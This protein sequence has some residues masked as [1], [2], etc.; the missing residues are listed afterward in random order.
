MARNLMAMM[1]WCCASCPAYYPPLEPRR[2]PRTDARHSAPAPPA[3]ACNAAGRPSGGSLLYPQWS[4]VGV[5][6]G[7]GGGRQARVSGRRGA[8]EVGGRGVGLGSKVIYQ[9]GRTE[10]RKGGK[11]Q[12]DMD[13]LCGT[14]GP[15][16]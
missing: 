10:D 4:R 6:E 15:P 9:L 1:A 12:V 8:E 7:G 3:P 16:A 11:G 13:G 14:G 5:G 2:A